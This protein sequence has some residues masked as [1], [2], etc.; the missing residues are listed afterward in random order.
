MEERELA[1]MLERV[2]GQGLPEGVEEFRDDLLA[3]CLDAIDDKVVAFELA[4]D[5]LEMLAAAGDL[6]SLGELPPL[7]ADETE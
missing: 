6:A 3:R 1:N 7:G 2:L 4:D 5:D